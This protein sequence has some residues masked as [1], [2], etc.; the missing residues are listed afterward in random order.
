LPFI[1]ANKAEFCA[2][3]RMAPN[4]PELFSAAAQAYKTSHSQWLAANLKG[5]LS[6]ADAKVEANNAVYTGLMM[7]LAV[8]NLHF[9]DTNATL[10]KQFMFSTLVAQVRTK[11]NAG[12]SGKVTDATGKP[13]KGAVI[14]L[15]DG[16][17]AT[18]TDENGKYELTPLSMGKYTVLCQ[19]GG[20]VT[21]TFPD[22]PIQTGVTARLNVK[23]VAEATLR[24]TA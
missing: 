15:E 7:G 11:G 18:E 21:Q 9:A 16:S 23:M 6:K 13:I 3:K 19:A 24:L 4:F 22:M 17:K 1:E 5:G 2:Q 12:I 10:A 8:G 20:F 14:S